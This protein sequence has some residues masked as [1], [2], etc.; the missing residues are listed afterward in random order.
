MPQDHDDSEILRHVFVRVPDELD[1]LPRRTTLE[2]A[3]VDHLRTGGHW[4]GV[5]G[6]LPL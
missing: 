6:W 4:Y 5:S 1:D 2:R 3:V